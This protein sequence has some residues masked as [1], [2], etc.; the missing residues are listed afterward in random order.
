MM[1]TLK[2]IKLE[3]GNESLHFALANADK[4]AALERFRGRC[5]PTWVF[6]ATGQLLKVMFGCNAPLIVNTIKEE[7]EYEL[8]CIEGTK[9]R[10]IR[11]FEE[12]TPEEIEKNNIIEEKRRKEEEIKQK[13]I[14]EQ[15][16]E[17]RQRYYER[18]ARATMKQSL[19]VFFPHTCQETEEGSKKRVCPAAY[20]LMAI[21]D[22]IEMGIKDQLDFQLTKE[23][24]PKIFYN[25]GTEFPETLLKSL[26]QQPCI[27]SLIQEYDAKDDNNRPIY[28]KKTHSLDYL[29]AVEKKLASLVYGET[30]DP[31]LPDPE[32]ICAE[33][34]FTTQN[35]EK[36]PPLWTPKEHLSKAAA[37]D[38]CFPYVINEVGIK[39]ESL[40]QPSFIMIFEA[41][42]AKEVLDAAEP[43]APHIMHIAFF[44]SIEPQTAKKVCQTIHELE[45]LPESKIEE[46]KMVVAL[47]K[48][49]SDP[50][51]VLAQLA[52]IYISGDI[53][54]GMKEVELFFPPTIEENIEP[55]PW[56]PPPA[57][58]LVEE[59]LTDDYGNQYKEEYVDDESGEAKLMKRIY[60]MADGT[61]V[62]ILIDFDG[63]IPEELIPSTNEEEGEV[64]EIILGQNES[65]KL[66]EDSES[67]VSL[68]AG[69][70]CEDKSK[71][72]TIES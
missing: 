61:P 32:S 17:I 53:R 55:D 24:I 26:E 64:S 52:P 37:M 38:V 63:E 13:E 39:I 40:P 7:F 1:S 67:Q 33:Y 72:S 8:G 60:F 42:N 29:D 34:M 15:W 62:D 54:E 5:E 19:V 10:I 30:M 58:K 36:V 3:I 51:L 46:T 23:T 28:N 45:K 43:Y 71:E 14:E 66:E 70:S 57:E 47:D 68:T 18:I 9:T 49:N 50:M 21:Y 69:P 48:S 16:V 25:C 4:I 31:L 56:G 59:Y 27:V 20:K 65:E 41:K 22:T 2:K 6:I 35:G 44:D 12:L 11:P